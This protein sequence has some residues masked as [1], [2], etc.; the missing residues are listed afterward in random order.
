MLFFWFHRIYFVVFR[1]AIFV[2]SCGVRVL[3]ARHAASTTLA[4]ILSHTVE[5]HQQTTVHTSWAPT[6][7]STDVE[8]EDNLLITLCQIKA[9]LLCNL[10]QACPAR[11]T[12]PSLRRRRTVIASVGR[13]LWKLNKWYAPRHCLTGGPIQ[14]VTKSPQREEG[15]TRNC[16]VEHY[17]L[18]YCTP[19]CWGKA[20]GHR[21]SAKAAPI[22]VI[23][24]MI[25]FLRSPVVI[26]PPR[27]LKL[28]SL[29]ND[30]RE[31]GEA[32]ASWGWI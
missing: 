17:E 24:D 7:R 10:F 27:Y 28:L 26:K 20:R 9:W 2:G 23:Y 16:K 5:R 19:Y 29:K 25:S 30:Q 8:H 21:S 13:W 3:Q 6:S 22:F 12:C 1:F 31:W 15:G 18:W 4:S 11:N 32:R 14:K